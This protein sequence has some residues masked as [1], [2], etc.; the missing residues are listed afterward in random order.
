MRIV[1]GSIKGD[2]LSLSLTT[3]FEVSGS[4]ITSGSGVVMITVKFSGGSRSASSIM[5]MDT[6]LLFV[7]ASKL[8]VVSV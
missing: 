3:T 2:L 1:D 8:S 4:T 6:Q 7:M 5:G